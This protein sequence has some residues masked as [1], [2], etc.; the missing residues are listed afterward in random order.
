MFEEEPPVGAGQV[1]AYAI[2]IFPFWPTDPQVW[3]VQVEAQFAE[4][5]ITAQYTMYHHIV[6]SL[7]LEIA[8]E[9]RDLL[10]WPPED[11]LYDILKQNVIKC[12]T[13]SEQCQLQQFFMA[14]DLGDQKPTWL[15]LQMQQLLGEKNRD[16]RWI[17]HRIIIHAAV[18]NQREDGSGGRE[19]ED[20]L[21]GIGDA[22]R[23]NYKGSHTLHCHYGCTITANER[24]RAAVSR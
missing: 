16:H 10:L 19:W 23:P 8:T 9:I 21:G 7:F 15:L 11:N 3:F 22:G 14:E 6:G 2:R 13:A 5:G 24:G 20:S 12:I 4:R 17:D 1:E 18:A